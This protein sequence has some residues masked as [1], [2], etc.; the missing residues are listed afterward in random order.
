MIN[1]V[2][3]VGAEAKIILLRGKKGTFVIK[4]RVKKSYRL[5]ELD[6]KIIDR[7]TRAE[8]RLLEKASSIINAPKPLFQPE[9]GKIKMPFISGKRL[10]ESLDKFSIQKQKKICNDIGKQIAKLHDADIIHGDLTTSNMVLSKDKLFFID[11][12]LGFISPK[13]ED[14]AVDMHLLKQALE[15]RHFSHWQTLFAEFLKGYKSSKHAKKTLEQFKK[16][17]ARGRYKDSY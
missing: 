12:G 15:A 16:V 10:S 9:F 11:F 6:K 1:K 4:N 14:K 2:L 8:A 5:P 3:Q 7:R 13:P 17:E